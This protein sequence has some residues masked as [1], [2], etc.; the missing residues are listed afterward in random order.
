MKQLILTNFSPIKA[1]NLGSLVIEKNNRVNF[2]QC[3]GASMHHDTILVSTAEEEEAGERL[4]RDWV[5]FHSFLMKY[6][7]SIY[8]YDSVRVSQDLE[9]V[10]ECAYLI[11]YRDI[12]GKIYS[13]ARSE[14]TK[15]KVLDYCDLFSK[16]CKLLQEEKNVIKNFLLNL[17]CNYSC[18]RPINPILNNQYWQLMVY[19]SVVEFI[20]G[21]QKPCMCNHR[22]DIDECNFA[23]NDIDHKSKSYMQHVQD[24]LTLR[25][26]DDEIRNQYYNC[27]K[28]C[29]SELRNDIVHRGLV[30][31]AEYTP[32]AANTTEEYDLSRSV[33]EYDK[34]FVALE[35]LLLMT[36]DVARNLLLDK[37]FD[38]GIF[39]QLSSLKSTNISR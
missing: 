3:N 24:Y 16:Y 19:Y 13:F 36:E 9:I 26:T 28:S 21:K 31:S 29:Y 12:A 22:C 39:L 35:S 10:G 17:S 1:I 15:E 7:H 25:I 4:I 5:V 33:E 23:K 18:S 30:P 20:I 14:E 32:Q 2:Y 6:K 37:L 34:D 8:H 11:D 27:I 38:T